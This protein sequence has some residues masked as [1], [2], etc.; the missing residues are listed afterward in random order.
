MVTDRGLWAKD[1][2][3]FIHI[4]RVI[5]KNEIKEVSIYQFD[6]Q[7]KLQAV[8]FAASGRYNTDT[9]QWQLSQVDK[10][11]INNEKDIT[12]SQ[13]LLMDWKINLNPE[14]LGVVSLEPDSL[15]IRGL[16]KYVKYLKES[17][18]EASVYQLSMWKKILSPL[19][20]VMMLMALSFILG[21]CEVWQ[22][23]KSIDG[24]S[25]GFIFICSMRVLVI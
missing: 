24:I 13:S 1:G 5:G 6:A 8:I 16:Y 20:A 2:N 12:G 9:H 22:W 3:D 23:G 15:P 7:K 18:Q 19:V 17:G 11:L 21:R 25:G 4:Q 10:S 14:K